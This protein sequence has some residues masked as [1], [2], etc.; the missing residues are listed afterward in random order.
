MAIHAGFRGRDASERGVLDASMTVTTID[1][2]VAHVMLVAE[3][4]GLI[5]S[6]PLIGDV[7][8]SGNNQYRRESN[9]GEDRGSKQTKPRN[10][11]RTAMKDL[12]HVSVALVRI[13]SPEGR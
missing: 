8:R 7:G 3:L 12:G 9:T 2:V 11:I 10:K 4:N 5:A 13:S 1:A 6:H